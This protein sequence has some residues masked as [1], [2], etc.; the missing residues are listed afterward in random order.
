MI[1]L[2]AR[3]VRKTFTSRGGHRV[4]ALRGVD[5]DVEPGGFLLVTGPSG[6]GKSTLLHVLAGLLRPD[7]GEV[8]W[9]GRRISDLPEARVTRLR[10]RHIGF[11]F[12]EE[13]YLDRFRVWENVTVLLAARGVGARERRARALEQLGRLGLAAWADHYPWELSG[14]QR[15]RVAL[16]RALVH[17]PAVVFADEPG[18]Q[19]DP[20]TGAHIARVLREENARGATVVV[21][22]HEPAWQRPGD[23]VVR[24][25]PACQVSEFRG[26]KSGRR[27]GSTGAHQ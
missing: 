24:L 23:R 13:R 25:E 6:S 20:D 8:W 18:A 9:D 1:P 22:S 2:R 5:L 12:Q 7:A 17:G 26:Q 16:A 14:G 4:E 3:G 21:A 11:A 19:V 15:Q 27:A 10:R